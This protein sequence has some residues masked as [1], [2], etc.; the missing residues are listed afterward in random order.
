[1][2]HI[3]QKIV[4]TIYKN[5]QKYNPNINQ[6][7]EFEQKLLGGGVGIIRVGGVGWDSGYGVNL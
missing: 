7:G 6:K 3:L 5:Q 1:M 2:N 4:Q